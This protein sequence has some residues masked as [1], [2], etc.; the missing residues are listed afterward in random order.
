MADQPGDIFTIPKRASKRIK[1]P[2][3]QFKVS[4]GLQLILLIM[5]VLLI[6]YN[7]LLQIRLELIVLHISKLRM[8]F[9]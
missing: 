1:I 2:K 7:K 6:A 3:I 5:V 8:V 4:R 9:S